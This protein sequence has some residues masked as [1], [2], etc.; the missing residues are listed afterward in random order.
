MVQASAGEIEG[1]FPRLSSRHFGKDPQPLSNI[2]SPSAVA[3]LFASVGAR[4]I[5][6]KVKGT[7]IAR[8]GSRTAA[9]A[10]QGG[11]WMRWGAAA[12]ATWQHP[13]HNQRATALVNA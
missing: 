12:V 2:R 4:G 8:T 3:R 9:R 5:K 11:A 1:N 6:F 7:R 13:G 10:P